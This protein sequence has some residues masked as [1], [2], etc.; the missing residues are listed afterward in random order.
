MDNKFN[1]NKIKRTKLIA[2]I[3]PASDSKEVL[4]SLFDAGMT[5]LR[6]NFSHG[7]HEEQ[8][9]RIEK[10]KEIQKEVGKPL[11]I[12]LDTKGPEIRVGKMKDGKQK[13]SSGQ[14]I[15]VYSMPDDFKNKVTG[16]GE[17]SVSYDM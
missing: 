8:L 12:M 17:I 9:G 10:A 7:D 6:L 4:R 15:T 5:T 1:I 2:T 3:G 14:K 13:I 11:S 16:Q